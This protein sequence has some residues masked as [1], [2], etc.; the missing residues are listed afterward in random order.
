VC[1]LLFLS[2]VQ[3]L[4]LGL[5]GEYI[6]RIYSEVKQ[7]PRWI[8]REALGWNGVRGHALNP[9]RSPLHLNRTAVLARLPLRGSSSMRMAT[10][11]LRV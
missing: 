7:R 1:L 10:G 11:K 5:L 9:R 6:G 4:I 8:V 3:F 2:G